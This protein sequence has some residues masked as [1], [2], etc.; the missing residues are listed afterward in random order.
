MLLDNDTVKRAYEAYGS[1]KKALE[2]RIGGVVIRGWS[3]KRQEIAFEQLIMKDLAIDVGA[4]DGLIG[5]QT[6]HALEVWQNRMRDLPT[7]SLTNL[8]PN[9]WPYEADVPRYYGPMGQNQL[10]VTPPY[11]IYLYDTKQRVEYITAHRKVTASLER[12]FGKVKEHYGAEQ[13]ND[14]HLNRFFGS[15]NVRRKRGGTTWSMH[16]WGIALDWDAN[17]NQLRMTSSQAAFAKPAYEPW[18]EIWE[19]EGWVSLGRRMNFDWMHVQAA[20]V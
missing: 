5:P 6:R 20:R 1:I 11:P 17:R 7:P 9:E 16:S 3:A 14:L 12:I 10:T 8:M 4:I 13:I 2:H 15:L 19:S 18:W